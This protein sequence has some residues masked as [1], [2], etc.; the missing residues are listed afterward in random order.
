MRELRIYTGCPGREKKLECW[1]ATAVVLAVMTLLQGGWVGFYE[2][3]WGMACCLRAVSR[4]IGG[5]PPH[6]G[7]CCQSANAP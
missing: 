7:C 1:A 4:V 5:L 3:S 6:R 2:I